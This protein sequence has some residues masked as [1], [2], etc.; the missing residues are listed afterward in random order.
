MCLLFI[1]ISCQKI[2]GE[3][4]IECARREREREKKEVEDRVSRRERE[5]ERKEVKEIRNLPSLSP[6][7]LQQDCAKANAGALSVLSLF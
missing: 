1:F 6:L 4:R 3:R 7:P 2:D 5:R